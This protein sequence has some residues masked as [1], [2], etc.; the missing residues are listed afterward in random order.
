M[1]YHYEARNDGKKS[2]QRKALTNKFS[3]N[4]RIERW[5]NILAN[6]QPTK[7]ERELT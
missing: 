7:G 2:S 6:Y 3:T 1:D 4:N 5:A